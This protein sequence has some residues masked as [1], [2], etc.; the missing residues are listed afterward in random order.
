MI[1]QPDPNTEAMPSHTVLPF[2]CRLCGTSGLRPV[3]S[4]GESPLANRLLTAEQLVDDEPRYALDVGYCSE[5]SLVQLTTAPPPHQLFDNYVYLSSFSDEM[6]EHARELTEQV[7]RGRRLTHDSLVIEVGS[8]DGYLLRN[9]VQAGIPVLGIDPAQNIAQ[10][11]WERHCVPTQCDFFGL[12][13]ANRLVAQ[14]ISAD[15]IHAHNVVA[16]VEDLNGVVAGMRTLLKPKGI[17]VVEVPYVRNLLEQVEFDTIYHEHRCY[18]SVTALRRLFA[19]NGLGIVHV[20]QLPIHGGSLRIVAAAHVRSMTKS[21]MELLRQ[22]SQWGVHQFETYQ[23]FGRRVQR[24]RNEL[25][26]LIQQLKSDGKRLAAYGASAKGTTLLN[27]CGLGSDELEWVADRSPVKCGKFTPGTHLQ[28]HGPEKLLQDMPDY[29]LLLTWN[30]KNEI[31]GQQ[32]EYRRRGGKFIVP[33]PQ[34][35]IV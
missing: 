35:E 14:G 21:V 1:R 22:E 34:P 27:Y 6:L 23:D 10:V 29:V 33:V 3:L 17:I 19:R 32:A 28:I 26:P 5:C 31:L 2:S 20:E 16:H 8:N 30:F 7:I 13:V 12:D 18:F 9:Y 11:A 25:R 15:V 4:L 24:L